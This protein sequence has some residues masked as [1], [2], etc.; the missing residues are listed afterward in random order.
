MGRSCLCALFVPDGE[1]RETRRV[2]SAVHGI[3]SET[4]PATVELFDAQ[5]TLLLTLR[6]TPPVEKLTFEDV[7][8]FFSLVDRISPRGRGAFSQ[9]AMARACCSGRGRLP[10]RSCS[11][12]RSTACRRMS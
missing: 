2:G 1:R 9:L 12:A 7:D 4:K 6:E 8:N 11:P 3:V 5:A 10:F